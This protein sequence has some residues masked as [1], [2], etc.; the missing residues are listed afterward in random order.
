MPRSAS[1]SRSVAYDLGACLWIG[2]AAL[3]AHYRQGN[4]TPRLGPAGLAQACRALVCGPAGSGA[5]QSAIFRSEWFMT[6]K[7]R[8]RKALA[9][10]IDPTISSSAAEGA[11]HWPLAIALPHT[12]LVSGDMEN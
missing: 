7:A 11:T 5:G 3:L 2:L 1:G 10:S 8:R 6:R 4:G 9:G 12:F